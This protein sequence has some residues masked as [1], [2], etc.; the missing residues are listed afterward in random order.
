M[1][2][3]TMFKRVA[4]VAVGVGMAASLTACGVESSKNAS[5]DPNEKATI[6]VAWWGSDSRLK[7]TQQVIDKF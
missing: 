3:T 2:W 6:R 1:K 7:L 4:A 5:A